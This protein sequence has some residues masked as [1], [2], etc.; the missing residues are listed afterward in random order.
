DQQ[1]DQTEGESVRGATDGLDDRA[2]DRVHH[3]EDQRHQYQSDYLR[4]DGV[5]GE[6]DARLPAE[7]TTDDILGE[8]E[9][10]DPQRDRADGESDHET[11]AGDRAMPAASV[12]SP[13]IPLAVPPTGTGLASA[14]G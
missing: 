3:S 6:R 14:D 1:R 4:A 12:L 2:E 9:R 8:Q 11:H 13:I 7:D 5:V 10:G